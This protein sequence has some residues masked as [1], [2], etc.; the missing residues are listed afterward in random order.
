MAS[1]IIDNAAG[2]NDV[3]ACGL[4]IDLFWSMHRQMSDLVKMEKGRL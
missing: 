1:C 2:I 4:E 3:T